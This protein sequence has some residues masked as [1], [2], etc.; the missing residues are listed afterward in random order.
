MILIT[1]SG[2]IG[3][4]V[5]VNASFEGAVGSPDLLRIV[6]DPD[7]IPSGYLYAFLS[8]KFGRALIEQ[9]TYG[10][11]VPHI[12]AHHVTDLPIPRLDPATEQRIH[13]MIERA[14]ALRVAANEELQK[15]KQNLNEE[16]L[17]IPKGHKT[18]YPDEWSYDVSVT[19]L[20]NNTRLDPFHYV[21]HANEYRGYLKPG[22]I[23]RDLAHVQLPGKFKRM[24]VGPEGIPY[25]SGVDVY[26]VK[27]TPR[28]WISRRQPELPKLVIAEEGTVLVQADGQR[29]GLL[30]RPMYV[31]E[32]ITGAAFSN[33]L[34]R[35][36]PYESA[37]GGYIFLFLLTDT[38]RR[39]LIRQSYGTSIPTIPISSFENLC[40]SSAD[41][42]IAREMGQKTL[43]ALKKRTH[44][45]L[46][47]DEAQ[48]LL[49]AALGWH[50]N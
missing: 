11:V 30:G 45:N 36:R 23:L 5:Y 44:S 42:E 20:D 40:I 25:L 41:T 35:I 26:Q 10:A 7:I 49:L 18:H 29:Y 13:E 8:S 46:L 47:E 16:I 38:G 28:L 22:P 12:E 43:D 48:A 39:E 3:N 1:C 31:D 6:A 4:T 21:G 2:I 27:V 9:K 19:H 32:Y 50:D 34:V 24:Y 15:L 33:H 17:G 14:A 37:T